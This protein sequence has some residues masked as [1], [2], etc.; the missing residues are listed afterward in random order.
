[1]NGVV[2]DI[3]YTA[4]IGFTSL[5]YQFHVRMKFQTDPVYIPIWLYVEYEKFEYTCFQSFICL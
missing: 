3:Q 5:L 1:M 2:S 4:K